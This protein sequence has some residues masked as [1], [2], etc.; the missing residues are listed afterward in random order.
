MF[1]YRI[2]TDEVMKDGSRKSFLVSSLEDIEQ[3]RKIVAERGHMIMREDTL[4]PFPTEMYRHAFS[5]VSDMCYNRMHD[6]ENGDRPFDKEKYD[7]LEKLKE[8][9]ERMLALPLP[10]AWLESKELDTAILLVGLSEEQR[11]RTIEKSGLVK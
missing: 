9:A 2:T 4:Y 1:W 10:V 11:N 7:K 8:D 3:K 5:H 6:M